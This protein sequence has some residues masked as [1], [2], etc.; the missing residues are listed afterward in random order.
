MNDF[1]ALSFFDQQWQNVKTFWENNAGNYFN[2]LIVILFVLLITF[3]SLKLAHSVTTK[4]I[5]RKN[6]AGGNESASHQDIK[7]KTLLPLLLSLERYTIYFIGF[8]I[9]LREIGID[10]SAILASAGVL[11]LAIGFGAQNT[12]K[13]FISGFFLIFDGLIMVD[14]VIAI[15]DVTGVVEKID[16]RNTLVRDFHGRLWSFP[17]G[18]VRTFGNYNRQWTRAIAEVGMAYE[19]DVSTGINALKEVAEQ[20]ASENPDLV[21]E[22]PEAQGV[23]SLD[24]SCVALRIVAKVKPDQKWAVERDLRWRIKDYFD[25]ND[26]EIPFPRRVV[27]HKKDE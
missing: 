27:Y 4:I 9:I 15:S 10:T 14:D 3:V 16:L 22:K 13:D 23:L 1:D 12:V 7:A 17:N 20:W 11:G 5:N 8:I 25:K 6:S 21:V 26:I 18:D 2:S 19:Q 24:D